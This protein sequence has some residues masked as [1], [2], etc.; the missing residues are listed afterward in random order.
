MEYNLDEKKLK[1]TCINFSDEIVKDEKF[2]KNKDVTIFNSSILQL[3]NSDD[4]LISSRGWYGNIRSWDGVNFIILSLFDK[5]FKK[6]KQNIIGID[7]KALQDKDLQFK[8]FKESQKNIIP[9]GEKLLKGPED[10]RLFY[11]KDDIYILIN[12]LTP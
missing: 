11:L 9:H 4:M 10:P 1:L 3:K 12:D 5:E 7:L 8:E 6:K 2:L